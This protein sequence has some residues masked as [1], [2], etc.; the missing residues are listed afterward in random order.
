MS[1]Q[2]GLYIA[3]IGMVTPV[4]ANTAMTA[5]AVKAGVSGYQASGYFTRKTRQPITMTGVPLEVFMSMQ[6]EIDEGSY[7]SAQYD[8]IIKMAILALREAVSRQS[9]KKPVPLILAIPETHPNVSY[10]KPEALI[11]NLI[12]QKDL[13]LHAD[14][15]RCIDTGRAA[16]IEGLELARHY[17]YQQKADYVLLGGSDSHWVYPRLGE[18]DKADR[19]LAPDSMDGF[20]PGEGAGFLLLTRHPERAMTQDGHIIA[21]ARP[22]VSQEPGHLF[23]DQTYRGDGLDQAFKQ[24]LSDHTGD[25]IHTVYSSMNG[26]HHWAKEYGVAYTRNQA[27]FLDPVK[28]AHPADC[29]GDLGAATGPVLIGLAA[30]SLW[31]QPGLATH[32][33]YSS[34]DGAW[35][36]AVRV[37]KM[38]KLAST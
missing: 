37:E 24:A 30:D 16:G 33:V 28:V 7:Y 10:I 36:A 9:I 22:G 29:Y 32:L 17:L 14:L 4:G 15:V 31:K 21:I 38:P 8:H 35:R 34:S 11:K 13:P 25:G 3:G 6:V 26:E 18:L 23:S 1:D 2:S 20:A 19:V 12:N 27:S 5:A